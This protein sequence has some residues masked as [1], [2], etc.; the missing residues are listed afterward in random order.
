[1]PSRIYSGTLVGVDGALVEVE[2]DVSPG[3]VRFGVVG[4]PDAAVNEARERVRSALRNSGFRFPQ[5]RVLVNLAPAD[6]RKEGTGFDLP[7]ALGILLEAGYLEGG[8]EDL[9]IV[10]ELSLEGRVRRVPGVLGIAIMAKREG[11]RGV[12][13]PQ[14]NRKEA[15]LVEDLEV[16][17]VDTLLEAV[18]ALRGERAP[19]QEPRPTP[20]PPKYEVDF[21]EIRGLPGARRA[22]EVAAAGGHNLLMVGPPGAG[23]T[24][25]AQRLPTILPPMEWEEILEVTQVYSAAGLLNEER[26]LIL[27]RPFRAPHHSISVAGMAGGGSQPRPGEVS[28]A[29]C[30]VLF[31]DE[32]PHFSRDVLELLRAPME[33]GRITISRAQGRATYPARFQ[34]VAAMNPCPCGYYGDPQKPCRCEPYKIRRYLQRISGPLLDRM[35]MVIQVPR[36]EYRE[37][38]G[39]AGEP[40]EKIRERVRA[41]RER[42]QARFRGQKVRLNAHM[43]PRLL[44]KYCRL[45]AEAEQMLEAA[46]QR[47]ALSG[48]A[49]TKILK[50]A[51]TIADL[52]GSEDI[53]IPHLAEALQYRAS[54]LLQDFFS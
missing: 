48:R 8:R 53:G 33:D 20:G 34:L 23:K 52:A 24:M 21:A 45:P 27:E 15:L 40:S 50:L 44:K 25:L 16:Y 10:G 4:L 42:M 54:E 38:K 46:V 6:L 28:L 5:R 36:I 14:E 3:V 17:P 49:I 32:F 26:P 13:V 41:A 12:V 1:M 43:T 2:V 51:R 37:W 30:G 19:T 35:D 39:E 9:V 7:I 18:E 31:L 47:F 29:H 22:L 11:F